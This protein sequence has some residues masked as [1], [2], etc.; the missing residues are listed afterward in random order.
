MKKILVWV[1][2]LLCICS[3][4]LAEDNSIPLSLVREAVEKFYGYQEGNFNY[5]GS[6]PALSIFQ[7][8]DIS[9]SLGKNTSYLHFYIP[10]ILNLKTGENTLIIYAKIDGFS[11]FT[12][13]F[14]TFEELKN[15][16][17]EEFSTLEEKYEDDSYIYTTHDNIVKVY[18]QIDNLNGKIH[19]T[20]R[21]SDFL[22]KWQ[23]SELDTNLLY[24][25][26]FDGKTLGPLEKIDG[27]TE[28]ELYNAFYQM[29]YTGISK[30][31]IISFATEVE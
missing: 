23:T 17:A 14:K 30:P 4:A 6:E 16:T 24:E 29:L 2:I 3:Q 5:V 25:L 18:A 19:Y 20:Y 8:G 9:C 10:K 22:E 11:L 27:Y 31:D 26:D 7:K 15:V 1:L 12:G 13:W 28:A 21:H